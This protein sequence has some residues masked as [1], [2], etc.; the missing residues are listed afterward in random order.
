MHLV[1]A[2]RNLPAFRCELGLTWFSPAFASLTHALKF[3]LPDMIALR[4]QL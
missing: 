1:V 3:L 4:S 2:G